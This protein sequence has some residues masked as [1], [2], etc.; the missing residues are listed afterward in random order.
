M[1]KR[2]ISNPISCC[3]LDM[4]LSTYHMHSDS[5]PMSTF[6]GPHVSDFLTWALTLALTFAKKPQE[7][8]WS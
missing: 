5:L 1:Y 3:D 6:L 4:P 2:D 8:V 7:S